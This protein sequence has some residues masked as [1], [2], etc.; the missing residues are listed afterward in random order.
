MP[1]VAPLPP[2]L[3]DSAFVFQRAPRLRVTLLAPALVRVGMHPHHESL[4]PALDDLAVWPAMLD[5]IRL[6]LWRLAFW[7]VIIG[8]HLLTFLDGKGWM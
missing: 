8:L 4:R 3:F 7:L 6:S 5:G 1:P 2:V